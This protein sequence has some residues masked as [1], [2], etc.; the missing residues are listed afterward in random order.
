[1]IRN[2]LIITATGLG[3]AIV[4]IGGGLAVGGADLAKHDW[5][6]VV[7]DN[8]R[9]GDSFNIQR[10]EIAPDVTRA[11][12]WSGGD[13]LSVSMPGKVVYI[14]GDTPG[15]RVTGAQGLVDRVRFENGRLT[16]AS[17]AED[18]GTERAYIRWG[19]NGI[20][21]WSEHERLRVVVTAPAVK[22]FTMGDD[23]ELEIKDYDQ[24]TLTVTA[25]GEGDVTVKG[26]ARTVDVT[27]NGDGYVSLR[28]L[29]VQDA[30]VRV[31]GDGD[32]SVGPTGKAD[33][34]ITG[35]GD[36]TLTR[37]P[38]E[39]SQNIVGEGTVYED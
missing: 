22:T 11:I 4:G 1:M 25:N 29:L 20:H 7:S 36:V 10:G 37:R 21:G 38:A 17:S 13:S 23:G 8:D 5:T 31:N 39:T 14:Q 27:T 6:W 18:D 16:L 12:A 35:D 34:E 2:L 15:I 30:K 19:R 24:P 32:I 9:N 33:I 28:G 26:E 3:L